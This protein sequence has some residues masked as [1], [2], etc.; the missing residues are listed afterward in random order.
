MFSV[1]R[2]QQLWK[3]AHYRS[4]MVL[5]SCLVYSLSACAAEEDFNGALRAANAKNTSQLEQYRWSMEHDAL[6]Y[7]PEYFLLNNN[8]ASQ[9]ANAIIQFAQRHANSAMAEKL[10]ADYV[11]EKAKI[12]DYASARAV[13]PYVKNADASENCAIALAQKNQG[14]RTTATMVRDVFWTTNSQPAL[15]TQLASTLN[16]SP[17]F[18]QAE[19]QARFWALLRNGSS[20]EAVAIGQQLGVNVS[21]SSLSQIKANPQNYLWSAPKATATDHAYLIF[22]LG[23]LADNDLASA[24]SM[25]EQ[26]A[27]GVPQDVQ[28]ALYRTVAYVGGTTVGKNNFNQQVLQYFQKSEGYYLNPEEAEIYARQALRFGAWD[29]LLSAIKQMTPV[30]QA[31]DRWQYWLARAYEKKGNSSTAKQLYRQLAKRGDDY[32]YLWAKARL[33][34]SLQHRQNYQPTS[35]DYQRL[36]QNIHFRRA[37]ALRDVNAPETYVNREWNWAVRQAY[38]Q[39]DDGMILAA[40]KRAI[41][42]GWYDRG[43]YAAERTIKLHN[44]QYRYVMPY[45]DQVVSYSQNAG[46]NPAWAYAIMRQE[47]R[48]NAHARSGVG[49]TGL[50][51]IMPATARTIARDMGEGTANIANASSNIRYG[52]WYLSM[53]MR[54]A[55]NPVVVTAGYNAG[56]NRALRW[57]PNSSPI[58]ADQYTESIPFTETRD[59]V[60]HVMTNATHYSVELGQGYTSI[61]QRMPTVNVRY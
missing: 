56:P 7:Y 28:R 1:Q 44:Y 29:S 19:K 16:S 22:A 18:T 5:S 8:L 14:D 15:C 50:M 42:M 3:K 21:F 12:G 31:E 9:P 48:F 24:L 57:Q 59:Y 11:E 32:Y 47:S 27:Q 34:E 38:L 4:M 51:Q 37:F 33:G 54:E 45:K 26:V 41:D 10:A 23:R 40:A 35:A 30:Q 43:I 55:N 39:H 25:V 52:T 13:I 61:E 49:A 46:I 20:S 2:T 58:D 36:S 60:K 17:M 6:G 53:L